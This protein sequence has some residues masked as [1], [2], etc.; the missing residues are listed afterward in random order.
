MRSRKPSART[1]ER[2]IPLSARVVG[3]PSDREQPL[4]QRGCLAA[5]TWHS[6]PGEEESGGRHPS[7]VSLTARVV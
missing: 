6:L 2:T 4:A 3:E 5:R 1:E 7:G